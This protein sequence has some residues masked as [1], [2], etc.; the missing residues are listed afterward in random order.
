MLQVTSLFQTK[1]V[2]VVSGVGGGGNFFHSRF[3]PRL[4]HTS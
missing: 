1:C 2:I 4:I 3:L